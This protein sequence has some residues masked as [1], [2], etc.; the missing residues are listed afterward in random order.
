MLDEPSRLLKSIKVSC[1]TD[2]IRLLL[3]LPIIIIDIPAFSPFCVTCD[4]Q[5]SNASLPGYQITVTVSS[6]MTE[7][8]EA[9]GR[10]ALYPRHA[11]GRPLT[12]KT[13]PA[14]RRPN[15][16]VTYMCLF[17]LACIFLIASRCSACMS[18]VLMAC[19]KTFSRYC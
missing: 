4:A 15:D 7:K 19:S 16:E 13:T 14:P 2:M 17:A 10:I 18:V 12:S 3:N 5:S 1:C 9:F 11:T 8:N 6:L